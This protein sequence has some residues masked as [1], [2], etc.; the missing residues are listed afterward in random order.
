MRIERHG[1]Q[2]DRVAVV[3]PGV[4]YTPARP[5]LHFVRAVLER[6]RWS[7]VELWWEYGARPDDVSPPDWVG[8]HLEAALAELPSRAQTLIVGKSLGTLAAAIAADRGLPAVWLTPLLQ[9]PAV[10]EAIAGSRASTLVVCGDADDATPA[11]A[12][13]RIKPAELV[14]IDGGDHSLETGDPLGSIDAL[15][16]VVAA[17]DEFVA[18]MS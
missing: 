2:S 5:L 7:A 16:R 14:V 1:S 13:A 15:R 12:L 4:G 9:F 10:A 11:E 17:V 18:R 8:A 3:L 6:H